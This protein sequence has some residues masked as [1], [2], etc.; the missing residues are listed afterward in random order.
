MIYLV[1][2]QSEGASQFDSERALIG[3]LGLLH[4]EGRKVKFAGEDLYSRGE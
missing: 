3:V 2:K 4:G 1:L